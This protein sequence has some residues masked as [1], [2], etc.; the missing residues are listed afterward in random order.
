MPLPQTTSPEEIL[1]DA[2]TVAVLGMKAEPGEP[3]HDIPTFL[4][5]QGYRIIPVNPKLAEAGYP[6]AVASLTDLDQ[7]PDVVEVFRRP[8]A[9]PQHLDEL[10]A[11]RPGAV[12]FQEGIRNDAVAEQLEQAGIPVVQDRCMGETLRA[13]QQA[14]D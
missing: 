3:A 2:H 11:L 9:I 5:E 4:A 10:L 1:R 8:E 6:G 14:G 13:M 7:A 12:W